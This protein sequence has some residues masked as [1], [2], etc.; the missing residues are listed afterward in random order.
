MLSDYHNIA[1][2]GRELLNTAP[3][4]DYERFK[5]IMIEFDVFGPHRF[6]ELRMW[7]VGKTGFHMPKSPSQFFGKQKWAGWGQIRQAIAEG[8]NS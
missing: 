5:E 7:L 6:A 2:K 4:P 1:A 3:S 8:R